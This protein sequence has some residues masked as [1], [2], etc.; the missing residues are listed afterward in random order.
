MTRDGKPVP[1]G[2]GLVQRVQCRADELS[3]RAGENAGVRV[4]GDDVARAG[5]GIPVARDREGALLPA[6]ESCKL[7]QCAALALVA[8]VALA[9]EAALTQKEIEAAAVFFVE[10]VDGLLRLRDQGSVL[11]C[12]LG[13][14]P[15]QIGK[16]AEQKIFPLAAAGKA[17]LLQAF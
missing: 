7:R 4:E 14:R 10:G 11:R 2:D 9:V 8:A 12:G 16:Q 17:Q 1:A 6:Q 5:K 3:K 13:L 15:G